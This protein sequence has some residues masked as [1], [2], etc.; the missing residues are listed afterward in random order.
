[1]KFGKSPLNSFSREIFLKKKLTTAHMHARTHAHTWL[2]LYK[3]IINGIIKE[4]CI[5]KFNLPNFLM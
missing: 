2:S 1:M 4:I 3:S 5:H